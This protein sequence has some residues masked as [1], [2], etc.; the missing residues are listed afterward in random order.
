MAII[1]E[2]TVIQGNHIEQPYAIQHSDSGT[3]QVAPAMAGLILSWLNQIEL[4]LQ[5]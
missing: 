2:F 1:G 4:I 3:G 5:V